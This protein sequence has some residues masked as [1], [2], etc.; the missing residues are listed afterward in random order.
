[1]SGRFAAAFVRLLLSVNERMLGSPNGRRNVLE[2]PGD[3][4]LTE[5]DGPFIERDGRPIPAGDVMRV[6]KNIAV[7]KRLRV[8]DVRSMIVKNVLSLT[9]R[10]ASH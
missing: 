4:L 3:R 6:V 8:A 2:I 7:L 9:G 5:T 1:M 10:S